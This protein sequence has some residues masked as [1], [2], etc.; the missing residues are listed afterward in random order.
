M[1]LTNTKRVLGYEAEVLEKRIKKSSKVDEGDLKKSIDI[2]YD[3]DSNIL[4]MSLTAEHYSYWVDQGRKPGIGM[5]VKPLKE[6]IKRKKLTVKDINGKTL[7]M[8][9]SR[10]NGLSYVI[11]RKIREK[12]IKATHFIE[13]PVELMFDTIGDRLSDAFS[14]DIENYLLGNQ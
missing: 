5:P 9:D 14:K 6:W 4:T 2:S 7:K 8:T 3:V 13:D 12:G 11:N 1:K 10:L